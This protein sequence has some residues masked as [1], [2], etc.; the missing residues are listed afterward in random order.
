[1]VEGYLDYIDKKSER[2]K[3]EYKQS[4]LE[5]YA[6]KGW[7]DYGSPR[8]NSNDRVSAGKRIYK[9]YI[10]SRVY[11]V[12]ANDTT[13]VKVDGGRGYDN[14]SDETHDAMKRY[15][16]A[17]KAIPFEFRGV[18]ERVCCEDEEFVIKGKTER[19]KA[20]EKHSAASL[21]CMGLDRLIEHYRGKK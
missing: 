5:K 15:N 16:A 17:R 8:N 2:R 9:D 12:T 19:Q 13:R 20:Y 4:I 21:L 11:P 18:I 7:L 10:E 1:M 14:V 3:K 6:S